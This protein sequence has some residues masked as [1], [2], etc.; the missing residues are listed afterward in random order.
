M[1]KKIMTVEDSETLRKGI[2]SALRGAG[3]EVVEAENGRDAL[4]K[5]DGTPIDF[6]LTDFNMPRMNGIEFT[7]ELRTRS[8][9]KFTP[10]YFLTTE[11]KTMMK[12]IAKVAGATGWLAKPFEKDQL[13][14]IVRNSI[15]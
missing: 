2:S 9:Y 14:K 15:G 11:T 5:L 10:V 6:I 7:Q 4:S 1:T 13:L 12:Q 8:D 3:Y